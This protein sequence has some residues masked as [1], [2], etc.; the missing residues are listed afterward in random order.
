MVEKLRKNACLGRLAA[1]AFVAV[2]A[3]IAASPCIAARVYQLVDYPADQD[4]NSL[5][6]TITT[7][8]SAPLDSILDTAEILEW[9]WSIT[10]PI[11]VVASSSDFDFDDSEATR[12]RITN[13]SI[14]LPLATTVDRET[15]YLGLARRSP[16]PRGAVGHRITWSTRYDSMTGPQTT[17][18][19]STM[20]GDVLRGYLV[21]ALDR[22]WSDIVGC[23]DRGTG[24]SGNRPGYRDHVCGHP[25]CT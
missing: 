23:G 20:H 6:G 10:G 9:Q 25:L 11:P 1:S 12:V 22:H 21:R 18:S 5:S 7:T 3:S 15:A 13:S 16:V 19:A 17:Y 2:V 4:G 8:D 14:E 24:T